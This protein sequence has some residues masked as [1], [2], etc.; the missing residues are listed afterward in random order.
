METDSDGNE[1]EARG[2]EIKQAELL[3]I[4]V[5]PVPAN[6]NA[7]A[8]GY[9]AKDW[10]DLTP[11]GFAEKIN[12]P[13]LRKPETTDEYR[14]VPVPA[15]EGKHD[16]HQIRTINISPGQGIKALYCVDDKVIITYLFDAAEW[17]MDEAQQW[18][19]DNVK[20]A[21]PLDIDHLLGICFDGIKAEVS[22]LV[23]SLK[24]EVE[25]LR[26]EVSRLRKT[27]VPTD[28]YGFRSAGAGGRNGLSPAAMTDGDLTGQV[29]AAL[30]ALRTAVEGKT[31]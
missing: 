3:E 14:R 11:A 19:A 22:P 26:K 17:T 10:S 24:A 5:V 28:P 8:A 21:Q 31:E 12:A 30:Q 9:G 25:A 4:S 15:E 7:L 18:V 20:T 6:S 16:G 23:D 2:Y 1:V 29:S 13:V 27:V